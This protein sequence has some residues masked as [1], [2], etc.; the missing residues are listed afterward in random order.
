[1]PLLGKFRSTAGQCMKK[2]MIDR[3]EN[4]VPGL[5]ARKGHNYEAV[6]YRRRRKNLTLAKDLN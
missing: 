5:F 3:H 4:S 6:I 2:F 1:M